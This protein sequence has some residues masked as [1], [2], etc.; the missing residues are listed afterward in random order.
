[1]IKP[2]KVSED[3][4]L[5]EYIFFI[6]IKFHA[7]VV[8]TWLRRYGEA[9]YAMQCTLT[10]VSTSHASHSHISRCILLRFVVCMVN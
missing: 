1:M 10:L 6:Y 3:F 7:G 9:L 4:S 8:K 5:D 2:F